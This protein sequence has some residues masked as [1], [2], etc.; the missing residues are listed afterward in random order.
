M[1]F[2]ISFVKDLTY[3]CVTYR[4]SL[5][6]SS[7]YARPDAHPSI[8]HLRILFEKLE[9][10]LEEHL[11]RICV[12]VLNNTTFLMF[13]FGAPSDKLATQWRV[14]FICIYTY[15]YIVI[16]IYIDTSRIWNIFKCQDDGSCFQRLVY[17]GNSN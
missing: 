4:M 17:V 8:L 11:K 15:I 5:R 13:C 1:V 2:V 6:V 7:V 16:Y 12:H 14:K 10:A 9:R 3:D